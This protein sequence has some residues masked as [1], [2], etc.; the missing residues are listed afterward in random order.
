[1]LTGLLVY[2]CNVSPR[3]RRIL[4]RWWYSKLARQIQNERWTFMNYGYL[5]QTDGDSSLRLDAADEPDRFCIQLYERVTQPADLA[6]RAVLE[7]GSGRGGG[8]SYLARYRTPANMTG[9]DFS[10]QAVSFSS[11]RHKAVSNLRFTTGDAEHL[12][13]E[14]E[15]FDA[16]VNV[17]SSH[18][19]GNVAQFFPEACRV[20]RPG[21]W[22]LFA[23]LCEAADAPKLEAA[24]RAVPWALVETED[25]TA[26]VLAALEADDR[27][28]RALIEE[29]VPPGLQ[30]VFAEFAGMTGGKIHRSFQAG[31]LVYL[32]F[33]CRK[34]SAN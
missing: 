11:E 9:V 23:D 5:P 12:P 2:L 7:V 28:K 4:W 3:L 33:A 13:F 14:N 31:K 30:P 21:G 18:C 20:L 1:M 34:S 26:R 8:A 16:V 22:F 17:E 32:R 25:I 19:Y 29:L 27:R 24:L 6:G 10:P 15:T